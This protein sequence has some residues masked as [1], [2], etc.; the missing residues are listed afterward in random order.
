MSRITVNPRFREYRLNR[1][2]SVSTDDD[3]WTWN[4]INEVTGLAAPRAY[5][6]Y[7]AAKAEAAH[8]KLHYRAVE[9]GEDRA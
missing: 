3:G 2:A 8:I 5:P 7:S 9:S 4:V 1:F 6:T